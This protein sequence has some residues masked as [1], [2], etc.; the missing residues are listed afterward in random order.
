MRGPCRIFRIK[1]KDLDDTGPG[2]TCPEKDGHV[3][4]VPH[5]EETKAAGEAVPASNLL[6]DPT[7]P[8]RSVC[9]PGSLSSQYIA[10]HCFRGGDF[11]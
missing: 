11:P 1:G 8:G 6:T 10:D 9:A 7:A 4:N 2:P 5:N 3:A